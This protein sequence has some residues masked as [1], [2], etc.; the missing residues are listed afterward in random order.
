VIEAVEAMVRTV[1][2]EVGGVLKGSRRAEVTA[3]FT[4]E[5]SEVMGFWQKL[6]QLSR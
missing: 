5:S 2:A 4:D 1:A 6:Y 3:A